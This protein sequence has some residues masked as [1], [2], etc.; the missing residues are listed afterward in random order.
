MKVIELDTNHPLR[1]RIVTE[2]AIVSVRKN[3]WLREV[4]TIAKSNPDWSRQECEHNAAIRF[5]KGA[6]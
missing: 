3:N 2:G 6:K 4:N 5:I 1:V